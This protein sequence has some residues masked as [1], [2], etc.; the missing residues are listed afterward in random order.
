MGQAI[1][2]CSQLSGLC[3]TRGRPYQSFWEFRVLVGTSLIDLVLGE[4]LYR[5]KVDALELGPD[6]KGFLELRIAKVGALELSLDK[7]GALELSLD[8]DGALEL[9]PDKDGALEL[10]LDK[11]G[12]L[13]LGQA[14]VGALEI[15]VT[16]IKVWGLP[17][18]KCSCT[19]S[20]DSENRLDIRGWLPFR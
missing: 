11:D 9:G 16:Q 18:F 4:I 3:R 12:A 17:I 14:K 13:E 2:R 19:P 15:R 8:K 20:D 5:C 10:S 1:R 6:K 7:D